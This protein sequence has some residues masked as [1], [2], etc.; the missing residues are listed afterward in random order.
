MGFEK[1]NIKG[2]VEIP[3]RFEHESF[4]AGF[5][6][7]PPN[8]V[9][10]EVLITSLGKDDNLKLYE[11]SHV[12]KIIDGNVYAVF[13]RRENVR[14]VV[15][16]RVCKWNRFNDVDGKA[17][18]C[19]S[20]ERKNASCQISGFALFVS[21]YGEAIDAINAGEA[22]MEAKNSWRWPNGLPEHVKKSTQEDAKP[23]KGGGVK[24]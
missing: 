23:A 22:E 9:G 15:D 21:T 1:S 20:V 16:M 2:W 7:F 24:G 3:E 11:R 5:I 19:T 18:D 17:V 12:H 6:E 13:S 8:I 4:D 14:A 10:G